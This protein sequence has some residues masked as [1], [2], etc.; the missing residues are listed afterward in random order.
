MSELEYRSFSSNASRISDS[1]TFM[2][3]ILLPGFP[4]LFFFFGPF[5]PRQSPVSRWNSP[6]EAP[7]REQKITC[8]HSDHGRKQYTACLLQC[9]K[10]VDLF[11]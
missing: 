11:H 2:I 8:H 3:C 1:L 9:D 5:G 10:Q 7:R 6:S 4:R